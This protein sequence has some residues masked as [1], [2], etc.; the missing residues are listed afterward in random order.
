MRYKMTFS[1]DGSNY[2]GSQRQKDIRTVELKLNEALSKMHKHDVVIVTSGRTDRGVHALNQVAHFDSDLNIEEKRFVKAVNS[3][4]PEDIIINEIKQVNDDFH[5][6]YHAVKKEYLYIITT[7]Y[8]IFKRNYE[9]YIYQDLDVDLMEKAIKLFEG[10]HDFKGFCSYVKDKPTVKTIYE[11][12]IKEENGKL[13]ITVIGDNFL[14]YMV[15]KMVG[16]LIDIGLKKKDISIINE[17][18]DTLD[19]KLCGKTAKP[20][21][22]YLKEVYY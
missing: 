11:S 12:K 18:F 6:R 10:T 21:G 8:D 14:R 2:F 17:I 13:L 4:L 9:T 15:R 1:Y 3:L 19:P 7:K 22:L 16:T 5:A 20:N